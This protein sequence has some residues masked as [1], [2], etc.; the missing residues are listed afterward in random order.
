[1]KVESVVFNGAPAWFVS[2][3]GVSYVSGSPPEPPE[4][5]RERAARAERVRVKLAEAKKFRGGYGV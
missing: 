5:E 1:M 4:R 2:D 3:R